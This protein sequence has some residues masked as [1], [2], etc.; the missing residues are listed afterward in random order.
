MKRKRRCLPATVCAKVIAYR[1]YNDLFGYDRFMFP[2]ELLF[3]DES[4]DKGK[5]LLFA[6]LISNLMNQQ[7]VL[8]EF[9]GF[10]SVAISLNQPMDGDNFL[11]KGKS[12]T[13]ADPT[14][15]NA[16]L[17]L[18]MKDFYTLK[19]QI[20]LL[21]KASEEFNEQD[22]IWRLALSFGAERCGAGK[23]YL[24]DEIGNSYITGFLTEKIN[25]QS[26]AVQVPFWL[27]LMKTTN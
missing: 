22:K 27:S 11:A 25:K 10:Y 24:K 14:F 13:I 18:V 4:N 16:P 17:G 20:K 7:A 8:V 3:R 9:P 12:Y 21:H 6:W 23:D 2:E 1:P 15:D 5:S 19:P 26:V